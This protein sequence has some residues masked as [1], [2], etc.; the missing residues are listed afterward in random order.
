MRRGRVGEVYNIGGNCEMANIDVVRSVCRILDEK[1]PR[2]DGVSYSAQI[3]FVKDR[4]AH[5]RRYAIDAGKIK[6]ELGWQ[7][8]QNFAFGLEKTVVWYLDNKKWVADI[9]DG[10]YR[11]E[12]IGRGESDVS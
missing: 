3:A 9:L 10:S 4:P 1:S 8:E 2:S 12:R 5:D 11:L 6:R 7:P